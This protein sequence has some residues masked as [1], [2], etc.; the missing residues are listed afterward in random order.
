MR[1]LIGY[2]RREIAMYYYHSLSYERTENNEIRFLGA[3]LG[4]EDDPY[5][6]Q[7]LNRT[8]TSREG[9]EIMF[10]HPVRLSAC[11]SLFSILAHFAKELCAK[12]SLL[13]DY[14]H[15]EC[16][17]QLSCLNDPA[18]QGIEKD[19]L[20]YVLMNTQHIRFDSMENNQFVLTMEY[21]LFEPLPDE[22]G[23]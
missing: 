1:R 4:L 6:Q 8:T 10:V 18:F 5:F 21:P 20:L 22:A 16:T 2:S 15:Y 9:D 12:A 19:L 3:D 14:A 11:R 13:I 23:E 17:L 7:Q